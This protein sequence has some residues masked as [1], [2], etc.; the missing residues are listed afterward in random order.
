MLNHQPAAAALHRNA[1]AR[2]GAPTPAIVLLRVA[3][4]LAIGV[5]VALLGNAYASL[6]MH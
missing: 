3:A 1:D 4:T 5:A 2:Q 6:A